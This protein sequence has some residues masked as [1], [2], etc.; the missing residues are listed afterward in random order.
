MY[1][2]QEKFT[3]SRLI[4]KTSAHITM[5][6]LTVY[7]VH[8]K[9]GIKSGK[10]LGKFYMSTFG[11]HASVIQQCVVEMGPT[12]NLNIACRNGERFATRLHR[13]FLL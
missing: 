5:A 8:P 1:Y 9:E 11:M 13:F 7:I 3:L 4:H 12:D 2:I 6:R 10:L